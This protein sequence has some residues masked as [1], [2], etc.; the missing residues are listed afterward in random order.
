LL[1]NGRLD[2]VNGGSGSIGWPNTKPVAAAAT[3]VPVPTSCCHEGSVSV[4]VVARGRCNNGQE[5]E[6]KSR[7]IQGCVGN[8]AGACVFVSVRGG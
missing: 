5:A 4:T 8:V 6:T 2:D 3:A 7:A 1:E